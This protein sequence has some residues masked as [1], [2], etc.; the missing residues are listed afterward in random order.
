[1]N[2][3]PAWD[4]RARAK[5]VGVNV[6][7]SIDEVAFAEQPRPEYRC[8]TNSVCLPRRYGVLAAI[9]EFGSPDT[10]IL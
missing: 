10:L 4:Q 3:A 2:I 8:A 9:A 6:G 5:R 7:G 1:M